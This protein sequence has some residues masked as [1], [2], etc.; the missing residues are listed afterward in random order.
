M[1]AR[2]QTPDF[3]SGADTGNIMLRVTL[4][5]FALLALAMPAQAQM[6]G[7]MPHSLPAGP[8]KTTPLIIQSDPPGAIA[9]LLYGAANAQTMTCATPC[10]MQVP[11]LVSFKLE[12]KLDGYY[13]SGISQHP[14]WAEP[15]GP[16]YG[17]KL[18]PDTVSFTLSK[19]PPP[20]PPLAELKE[21]ASGAA[22]I[23][24]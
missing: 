1:F 14:Q 20:I 18:K 3:S 5:A 2:D 17:V 9:V 10:T 22:A 21:G 13:M 16:Y 4:S 19:A 12:A 15:W 24:Q 7:N 8:V 6:T 11:Y 23:P